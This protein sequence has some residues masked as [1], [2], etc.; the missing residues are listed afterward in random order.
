GFK[1]NWMN[2]NINDSDWAK[3]KSPRALKIDCLKGHK[4][5]VWFRK[6]IYIP[7]KFKGKSIVIGFGRV[8]G[9]EVTWL[10]GKL[11]DKPF[12]IST[13]RNKRKYYIPATD[14]KIGSNTLIMC[15]FENND[16]GTP[17]EP[18]LTLKIYQK[19]N[20]S[21]EV[22]YTKEWLCK[23]GYD[24]TDYPK[25]PF[26]LTLR[27][28]ILSI[29]YNS[30]IY[31]ILPYAIRGAL[32]YQGESNRH[33]YEIYDKLFAAMI[34]SWR[35]KW[36]EGAFPFYFV[37]IAPFDYGKNNNSAFL[38]EAQFKT[39][40][41]T[42]NTG[43]AVIMD[44]GE[45]HNIH[46]LRKKE[47]GH[48]LALWALAKDYGYTN[49]VYSGPLY[50]NYKIEGDKIIV[51]FD[52]AKGLKT[53]DK[54]SLSCFEIAGND[55]KFYPAEA[56]II[57]D[58]IV[59]SSDKVNDPVAVRFAFTN[60][61]KPNLCNDAGLPASSFRTDAQ[62]TF[63]TVKYAKEHEAKGWSQVPQILNQIKPPTFPTNNV[64]LTDFGGKGDELTDNRKA[65]HDA[66]N[67]L[68]QKGGGKIIVPKG[69]Y[70][71]DGPIVFKN[72]I[73][74]EIQK[75][76]R[77][78]F[79][80][81]AEKYLPLVKQRWEGIVIYNYSPLIYGYQLKNIAITGEGTIDGAGTDWS[82]SWA[83]I[84]GK[85]QKLA[86]QMGSERL[87]EKQ[88]VF[89]N[90]FLD[91][92]GDG[93]DDSYGDGKKHFLRP[94]LIQFYECKNILI[95][96]LTIKGS[97]F[98]TVNPVFCKNFT[99]KNLN[100][101][102]H[103]CND[104]GIDVDSCE[105]VL[106]EGCNIKTGDD[107][108]AVKAGRDQDAW[109]RPGTKNIIIKN[110]RLSTYANAIC[111]GS[112]MSGG[113]SNVFIQSNIVIR[114]KHALCFK[115]NLD[116][117]GYVKNIFIKNINVELSDSA[118]F[119]FRTDYHG[120]RGNHFP[121][122]FNNFYVSGIT[123]KQVDEMPFKIIGVK[124]SLIQRIYLNN[125]KIDKA[126]KKSVF[127]FTKNIILNNITVKNNK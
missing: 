110:N 124:D 116:R 120:Y 69:D 78:F 34:K 13:G 117:G 88:R 19:D 20:P 11:I 93:K 36:G 37:Q 127:I 32:W 15:N 56:K 76:A 23:K 55:K 67:M 28:N 95:Q 86:R 3:I 94:P 53:R 54:K 41:L 106:I 39:L 112:E 18:I 85:D 108:I 24:N 12:E 59:V 82:K 75:N 99:L 50:K 97:P 65:F 21:N 33:N 125:I 64:L 22:E 40:A 49:L 46:P 126:A 10:N 122:K 4:G 77:V 31:P 62:S 73:H 89:G 81:N 83:R 121:P 44:I 91:L 118:M 113:V 6:K 45:K 80:T 35:E 70:L 96:G 72:N 1:N 8:T 90:G 109:N 92:N 29:H 38:R 107:N 71:V 25:T 115:C 103:A 27:N 57:N 123:C 63:F 47:V 48:R 26:S 61:V 60:M 100:I 87:P 9:Y 84:Q 43:M 98:W 2:P 79:T 119:I 101:S 102:G 16:C 17:G 111:I 58:E 114:A 14:Y 104:D 66:I 30:R 51:S 7:K 68:A 42:T 105:Y 52:Y 5:I 74:I